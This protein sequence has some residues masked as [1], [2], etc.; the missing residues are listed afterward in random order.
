MEESGGKDARGDGKQAVAPTPPPPQPDA[1]VCGHGLTRFLR[2]R[3]TA[4]CKW[5]KP[6]LDGRLPRLG[7]K[8]PG[9]PQWP[10]SPR[11]R[12]LRLLD[13]FGLVFVLVFSI[14]LLLNHIEPFGLANASKAQSMR[15][16]ARF[17]APFYKDSARDSTAVVLIDDRALQRLRMDWPPAYWQYDV[18]L[19]RVLEHR[20]RAVYLD[21]LLVDKRDYDDSFASTY[22]SLNEA[23]A[24]SGIPVFF[25]VAAPGQCSIFSAQG[26]V[27]DVVTAWQG[28]GTGYPLLVEGDYVHEGGARLDCPRTGAAGA[29]ARSVALAL[30]Q[31]AC[32]TGSEAGCTGSAAAFAEEEAR[33]PMA[34]Q[35]GWRPEIADGEGS[36]CEGP[37]DAAA[38]PPDPAWFVKLAAATRLMVDSFW[39]ADPGREDRGRAKCTFPFTVF[40]EDLEENEALMTL[41]PGGTPLLQDRVV[42]IGTRLVGLDD[43]VMSPVNQKV[44]GVYLHAMALDNLMRWG[45]RRVH[46]DARVG[47][48]AGLVMALLMSATAGWFLH[49]AA[50]RRLGF[51]RTWRLLASLAAIAAASILVLQGYLRQPPQDWLGVGALVLG[52]ALWAASM[53]AGRCSCG[54]GGN[55]DGQADRSDGAAGGPGPAGGGG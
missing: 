5:A 14:G 22:A 31:H 2:E 4:F 6:H 29:D 23:V 32:A 27:Q 54:A 44:P 42:L 24:S 7:Q 18:L 20:P 33:T 34:V 50:G 21:V 15:I 41:G 17:V 39:G 12:A 43:N 10:R 46:V 19:Q 28:A 13:A 35:W 11:G 51:W 36:R 30:Y 45:D 47:K 1:C 38:P 25:G 55:N 40:A 26:G 16:S 53:D 8:L 3:V 37:L 9:E 52:G 48:W 49:R